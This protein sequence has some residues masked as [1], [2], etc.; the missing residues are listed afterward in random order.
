MTKLL[1]YL[2]TFLL[3]VC[4]LV[5]LVDNL[6][7]SSEPEIYIWSRFRLA[8]ILALTCVSI[9][10]ALSLMSRKATIFNNWAIY[11][12][13]GTLAFIEAGIRI[14]PGIVPTPLIKFLPLD[15]RADLAAER[16]FFT[17]AILTGEGMVYRFKPHL[18]LP[19][20]PW[21]RIDANGYR[22][23]DQSMQNIDIVLLGDSIAIALQAEKDFTDFFRDAGFSAVNFGQGGYG[24][25]QYR[26]V[27][28][29]QISDP[30]IPH[31]A[32]V[33]VVTG[34]NDFN[35]ALQYS[36]LAGS[37]AGYQE[38]LGGQSIAGLNVK[39]KYFPWILAIPVNSVPSIKSALTGKGAAAPTIVKLP[40][41]EYAASDE[42][43]R[44]EPVSEEHLTWT[45]FVVAMNE[46]LALAADR[47]VPVLVAY[48]PPPQMTYGQFLVGAD[49]L[50]TRM[51]SS[52]DQL[53]GL[54]ARLFDRPN[55]RF[56]DLTE[57]ERAALEFEEIGILP[58]DTH[59]NTRG[60]RLVADKLLGELTLLGI[61]PNKR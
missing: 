40:Y 16:G 11:V 8:M 19:A 50:K 51:R 10:L 7:A 36:R 6:G 55:V 13:V 60:A 29:Q 28:R 17:D 47:K 37:N 12:V 52:H 26:D 42:L 9:A 49:E 45:H 18:T 24:P 34:S 57:T 23:P 38:Y 33:V 30:N 1:K 41:A 22:N 56:V 48:H 43:L 25:F 44:W 15:A 59:L 5:L 27:Y 46:L 3:L 35:N 2:P 4:S 39:S 31:R 21:V 32:L 53:V 20:F 54:M 14:V 58:M 61:T